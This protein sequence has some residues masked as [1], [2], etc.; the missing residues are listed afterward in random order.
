MSNSEI[1]KRAR[2]AVIQTGAQRIERLEQTHQGNAQAADHGGRGCLS[3]QPFLGQD[4]MSST[5]VANK[6]A[7]PMVELPSPFSY[8]R[9]TIRLL[10]DRD[11]TPEE[12][13]TKLLSEDYDR[14]FVFDDGNTRSLYFSL[15]Y[16]QSTM[17]T[18]DPTSLEFAY[19][20]KMMSFLLFQEK[21]RSILMLGLGGGSL[22]KFC[23]TH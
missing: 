12:L 15:R 3:R 2:R 9:G 13:L 18:S 7:W 20:R 17:R 21:T 11:L 10:E 4:E 23:Y 6:P 16:V 14:P 5:Q 22:A 1:G 8:E 19:T